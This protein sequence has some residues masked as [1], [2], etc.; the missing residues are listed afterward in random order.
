MKASIYAVTLSCA[1]EDGS[2]RL[3]VLSSESKI[4]AIHVATEGVTC[5]QEESTFLSHG[6]R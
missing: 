2:P 1:K 6:D 4:R 5:P 3:S